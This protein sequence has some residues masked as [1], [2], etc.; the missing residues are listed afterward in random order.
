MSDAR[1]A[2]AVISNSPTPYRNHVLGRLGREITGARLI[3]IFTH[4]VTSMPWATAMPPE[5]NAV[6]FD[7]VTI[8]SHRPINRNS[9][10]LFRRIR[11]RL[12]RENVRLIVLLGYNDLT[13][14]MLIRWA[15]RAGIPLLVTGDSNVFSEGR[16]PWVKRA[17]KRVYLNWV[18]THVAGLMPMGTAGRAYFRSYKDHDL[19]VFLFPYEPDYALFEKRDEAAEQALAER[20]GLKPG[21]RRIMYSGRFI[22]VKRVD[23]LID[24]FAEMAAQRPEWDLLIVGDGP[25]REE[26]HARVPANLRDRVTWT[27]F[28]QMEETARCY[29]LCEV[30]AHPSEYEPWALVINEA[31]ASG[32]VVVCTLVVGAAVELVRHGTNGRLVQPRSV[33]SMADGLLQVTTPGVTETMRAHAPEILQQWR[34]AAD[35]VEGV[36]GALRHFKVLA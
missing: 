13:R 27:G 10:P 24:A 33:E 7:D 3:S 32:L 11:D 22:P 2:Y 34:V 29:R 26:L 1:P 25:L 30:L 28:L 18:M 23:V 16:V 6:F 35:P 9:V 31:V 17:V 8:T 4:S 20:L 14:V 5:A 15:R 21:R 19:P 36:R 12:I